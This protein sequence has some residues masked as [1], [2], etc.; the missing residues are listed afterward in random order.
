[1]DVTHLWQDGW[2]HL[3]AIIDCHDREVI[4]YEFALRSRAKEAERAVEAACL[5]RFGTLRPVG[6]P[7]CLA[8]I[9]IAG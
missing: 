4:A 2:A 5:A 8:T 1:M 7:V 9:R 3:A 6:A